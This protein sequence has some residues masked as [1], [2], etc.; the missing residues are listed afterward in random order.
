[1]IRVV[2]RRVGQSS[3]DLPVSPVLFIGVCKPR[4]VP[5]A[6]SDLRLALPGFVSSKVLPTGKS[7]V[8][9]TSDC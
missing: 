9:L 8:R 7:G 4:I 2:R 1:M 5:S 6:A 3:G